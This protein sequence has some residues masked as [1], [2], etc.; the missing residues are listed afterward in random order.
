MSGTRV[1]STVVARAWERRKM[2]R[3]AAVV[4]AALLASVAV[5]QAAIVLFAVFS[6]DQG[7]LQTVSSDP[8]TLSASNPF[9]DPSIGTNGQACV[10]CHQPSIG[11]TI[12]APF[13]DSTFATS[14][15]T[16]PLFRPNDTANN[17][18]TIS[19]TAVDYGLILNLGVVR[20]GKTVPTGAAADFTVVAADADTNNN[21][22]APDSF[23]VMTDPQH[24]GT[25]TLSV[26]RRPLVNTNVNFDSSVLWDGRAN[27]ANLG[28]VAG[29]Q[30]EGAIQTL[31]LGAGTDATVNNSI[32][33]FL[34]GVFNRP[35]V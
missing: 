21:F 34:T 12:S 9:F 2:R 22:A 4:V 1:F 30:V 27:I 20:I 35:E 32:A 18:S 19:H 26:F 13:I 23:P 28:G 25:P 17:P 11:I 5:A 8:S 29:G 16:D 3:G 24:P 31:L 33:D 14:G 15:G 6:D 10:T 7:S